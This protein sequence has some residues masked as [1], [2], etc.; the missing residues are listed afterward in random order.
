MMQLHRPFESLR[1]VQGPLRQIAMWLLAC[2]TIGYSTGLLFVANTTGITP[3]GIEGRYRGNQDAVDAKREPG[4]SIDEA[5]SI[6]PQ[7]HDD[8]ELQFEKSYE[9]MLNITHTHI[10]SMASFFALVA[11]VFAYASR[12][13]RRMKM[14]LIVEPFVAIIVSFFAMWLMRYVD[15]AFSYL[16]MI[17][18]GSMAFCFYAMVLMSMRELVAR[19]QFPVPSID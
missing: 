18:S 16:L 12:P 4:T 14:L 10:L 19:R 1:D 2:L 15:P 11:V 5:V 3:A 8:Q 13:S 7:E 9:E 6:E 17:S